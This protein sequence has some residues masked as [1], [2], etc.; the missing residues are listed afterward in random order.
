MRKRISLMTAYHL[1]WWTRLFGV[2]IGA[3]VDAGRHEEGL[4]YGV[5]NEDLIGTHTLTEICYLAL[6]GNSPAPANMFAFQT[7][8]GLLL[9]NGPGT[10]SG[11]GAKG[12]VSADGPENPE[13]V[14]LNK[15]MN[16]AKFMSANYCK[17]AATTMCFTSITTRW[18]M[19]CTI[20]ASR[21][22]CIASIS[23]QSSQRCC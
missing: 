9:T 6:L 16:R 23:M 10:I 2:L 3:S 21:V 5:S 20:A 8:V 22:P 12:A 17:G 13:R 14:Q 1:P 15:A 4:F 19:P 18:C 7:L 11:Q